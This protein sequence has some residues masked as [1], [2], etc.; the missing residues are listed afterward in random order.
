MAGVE[1][2]EQ[3]I[4]RLDD[5]EQRQVLQDLQQARGGGQGE[6]AAR[7]TRLRAAFRDGPHWAAAAGAADTGLAPLSC[8]RQEEVAPALEDGHRLCD[9]P[10]PG[11]DRA[12]PGRQRRGS[13]GRCQVG[14]GLRHHP[15]VGTVPQPDLH[16]DRAADL[17]GAD[18]GRGGD[19]RHPRPRPH[20]LEAAGRCRACVR[21]SGRCP[22]G[23]PQ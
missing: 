18:H 7:R 6:L 12:C 15:G 16:A 19:G 13:A 3:V 21:P 20:R 11:T 2:I 5:P 17:L 22:G 8:C 10:G 1:R 23:V 14:N 9:R 4:A